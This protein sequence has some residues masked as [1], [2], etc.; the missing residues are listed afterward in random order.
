MHD[1]RCPLCWALGTCNIKLDK[2]TK[3]YFRCMACGS[4]VFFASLVCSQRFGYTL[5]ANDL[6]AQTMA[7]DPATR[8]AARDAARRLIEQPIRE[9][10]Q[11]ASVSTPIAHQPANQHD[12]DELFGEVINAAQ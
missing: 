12:P 4:T 11:R 7:N 2:R 8:A 9:L 6:L 3:P 5:Y 1:F 10:L